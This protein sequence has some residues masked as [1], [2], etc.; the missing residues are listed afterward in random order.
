[1]ALR[2]SDESEE[3]LGGFLFPPIMLKRDSHPEGV[4]CLKLFFNTICSRLIRIVKKNSVELYRNIV[5]LLL[6]VKDG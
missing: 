1:M 6:F 4:I 3:R 2:R 5:T